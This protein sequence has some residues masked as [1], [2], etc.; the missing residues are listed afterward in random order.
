MMYAKARGLSAS[1]TGNVDEA[2][3]EVH[4]LEPSPWLLCPRSLCLR[5]LCPRRLGR[6]GGSAGGQAGQRHR[7]RQRAEHLA[8]GGPGAEGWAHAT[9]WVSV[10]A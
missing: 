3:G 5:P 7:Q 10:P 4:P 1:S 9:D 6:R 8:R 2:D